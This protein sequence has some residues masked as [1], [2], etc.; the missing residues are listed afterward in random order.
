MDQTV[1]PPFS[2]RLA[3]GCLTLLH[4]LLPKSLYD[5]FYFFAFPRYKAWLR[6]SYRSRALSR[7][8]ADRDKV[9]TV[10]KCLEFSLV[11][12]QGMEATYQCTKDVLTQKIPGDLVECGVAQGGS[13]LLIALVNRKFS[14]RPR[15]LWLFDSYEGLPDPTTED[16]NNGKTGTHVR[17]L[18]KGS[19]LGTIEDVSRLLFDQHQ[20]PRESVRLVKGWFQDTL[21]T[22]RDK[23]G[24]IALL[25]LDGDWY[26]STKV[27]LE[28]LFDKVSPGGFVILDDYFSCYGCKRATDEFLSNRH[29]PYPIVPDGRGGAYFRK[30]A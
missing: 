12:W 4:K 27:C 1:T 16:Y 3:A 19:C 15:A 13:A 21:P 23:M 17:P 24:A 14:D 2:L 11:G 10:F 28:M 30:A 20:L 7:A 9:E 26:E 5:R 22:T 25:R 29:L 8:G 18:P 6:R